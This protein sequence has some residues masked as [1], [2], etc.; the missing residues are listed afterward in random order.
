M[1]RSIINYDEMLMNN[2]DTPVFSY[3]DN[4]SVKPNKS[5]KVYVKGK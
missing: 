4:P 3:D 1:K 2:R 5:D